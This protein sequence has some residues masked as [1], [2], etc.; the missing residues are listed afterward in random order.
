M[1]T[2]GDERMTNSEWE[3]ELRA[4]LGD[5]LRTDEPMAGHTTF[6]IGGPAEFFVTAENLEQLQAIIALAQRLGVP[7]FLLGGGSNVLV[8]DRGLRGLVVE[9]RAQEARFERRGAEATLHADSG[10]SISRLA[11][12]AARRG[13]SGLEWAAGI[14]GTVGG[15][16][17]GNAGAYGAFV[18]D[19][20]QRV[21]VLE[22][23]GQQRLYRAEEL[24]FGYRTSRFKRRE[25][26]GQ[27]QEVILWAEF[28]L[29]P[30][31]QA[32]LEPLV[33]GRIARRKATQPAE[34]SA[35]SVFKNPPGDY[36]GRL[37]E[38]AGLKGHR[39]GG[40]EV[41]GKHANF[42]VNRGQATAADVRAL[43]DLIR[44]TIRERFGV[45]LELE[46]LLVGEWE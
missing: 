11:R 34:P 44:E 23:D 33:E 1:M 21:A 22:P 15:A 4:V 45:E 14:P 29:E 19:S 20:L 5:R 37:I 32:G 41:A 42:I 7:Y 10:A 12:Q 9:N 16:V 8:S 46:I 17:V 30:A 31:S 36:A 27:G 25:A 3:T 6:R 39:I 26:G 18:A 40:A 28:R 35:G 24:G 43:I 38:A 13:L 2:N